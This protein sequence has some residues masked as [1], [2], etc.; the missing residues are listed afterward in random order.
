MSLRLV[1]RVLVVGHLVGLPPGTAALML[2]FI[3]PE[4]L[5]RFGGAQA[6]AQA[7]DACLD[8]LAGMLHEPAHL[9]RL[10]LGEA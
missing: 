9:R 2:K 6:Y 4:E 3:A 1:T 10:L 8:T 5:Q 7:I